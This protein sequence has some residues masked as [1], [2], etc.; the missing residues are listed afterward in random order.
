VLPDNRRAEIEANLAVLRHE[1]SAINAQ[2]LWMAP[3]DLPVMRKLG[4]DQLVPVSARAR[5]LARTM[6]LGII[7]RH[8]WPRFAK[9]AMRI[10]SRLG[11]SKLWLE[12]RGAGL[13]AWWLN[14]KTP[15]GKVAL[16]VR[17]WGRG[18]GA[19]ARGALR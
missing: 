5:H 14:L 7:A 4:N 3:A 13:F 12:P 16:P 2:Q 6:F 19:S 17:G 10:D 18:G 15:S 8:K 9:M 1:L 11:H